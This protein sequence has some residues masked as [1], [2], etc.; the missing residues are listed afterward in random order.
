[1]PAESMRG[2]G[3]GFKSRLQDSS[4]PHTAPT[5]SSIRALSTS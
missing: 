2:F 3:S 4:R 5:P 1:M